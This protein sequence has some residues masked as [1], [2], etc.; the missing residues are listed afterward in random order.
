LN[1]FAEKAYRRPLTDADR[2]PIRALYDK[3]L[4]EKATPRQAALDALKLILCSP[5]FLYL[6]EITD[7]SAKALKPYD[8]ATRLSFAL[9]AAPPDEALLAAAKSGKL[10]Q[11]AEL[12]KQ[13]ERMIADERISGF[14]NGFLDSWLNLRD[15]GGM[16]PPRENY[17]A[18]YAEDLPTSMKT[19]ARLFFRDLLKNNGSVAQFI[20]CEHTFVDKKLAKLYELPEKDKLRLADGFK[21]SASRATTIA[22]ACSAWL[23]CSP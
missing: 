17:R 19:E 23:R 13:I 20:D 5:S 21:K 4:A 22:A 1:A 10:T 11:D 8:L 6:S 7:E 2:Q 9:W 14:V 18:Y 12:K 15:L 3:R 16:P